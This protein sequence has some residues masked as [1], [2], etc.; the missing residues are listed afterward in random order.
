MPQLPAALSRSVAVSALRR[1]PVAIIFVGILI[2]LALAG[3]AAYVVWLGQQ[4]AATARVFGLALLASLLLALAALGVIGWLDRRERESPW[5]FFGI[6]LFGLVIS[7]GLG[8]LISGGAG[9]ALFDG[10]GLSATDARAFDPLVQAAL[11]LERM[12]RDEAIR[13]GLDAA[14]VA[15]LIEELLKA[16][17]VA[18]A[19][20]FLRGEFDNVRD[21][22][23]YGALAGLGF[24]VGETAYAVARSFAETG[25]AA[26]VQQFVAHFALLGLGGHTLFA[27]LLGAGFGLAREE[28]RRA[29]QVIAP[30]A[31]F[32]L[33]F[34]AHLVYNT[35]TLSVAGTIL[36]FLGLPDASL[37]TAP[38]AALWLAIVAAT[39]LTLG[40]FYVALGHLLERSGRWEQAV[41]RTELAG[42]VGKVITADEYRILLAEGLFSLRS[43]PNYPA[44]ISRAIVNAQNE[45]AFRKWRVRFE[46]GDPE[47][48][49]IVA[50]W[51]EDI[52]AWRAAGRGAA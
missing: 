17:A 3:A 36:A 32:L 14:L 2:L 6:F 41:I 42:E 27:A 38:P 31:F 46:G 12:G 23:V 15:P 16:L 25:S 28:R 48:D 22:L 21:G 26:F 49:A 51:R 52:A 7:S 1:S 24:A 8:L 35:L 39:A 10:I 20:L 13:L 33:A 18:L 34:F 37:E 29:M 4:T 30:L 45:L 43:A 50:G 47:A 5:V 44:R 9:V 11:P 40:L 19:F